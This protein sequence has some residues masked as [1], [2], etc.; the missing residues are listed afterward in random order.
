MTE[1]FSVVA[2]NRF[3]GVG[4]TL[5]GGAPPGRCLTIG[6][7]PVEAGINHA[8]VYQGSA[9]SWNTSWNPPGKRTTGLEPATFGLGS[10][11]STS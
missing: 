2:R 1:R 10:Q 6:S 9:T 4:L 11:R 3:L 7:A 5:V 8:V